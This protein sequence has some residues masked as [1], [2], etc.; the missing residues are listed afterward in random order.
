MEKDLSPLLDELPGL[1]W[2]ALPNGHLDFASLPWCEY[3]G[4]GLG[5]LYGEG[6]QRAIHPEDLPELLKRWRSILSAGEVNAMEARL[7]RFDGGYHWFTFRVRPLIDASGRIVKWLGLNVDI[8]DRGRSGRASEGLYRSITDTIPAMVFFMTPAGELES[9][10][11]HVLEYAGKTLEELKDW[12]SGNFVHADD[13]ASVIAAWDRSVTTGEPYDIE[14][15]MRR[16]DGI[17]RWFHVRGM[18]RRDVRGNI[19]RWYMIETDIDDRRRAETLL[20]GEKHLLEMTAAGSSMSDILAELCRFVEASTDGCYC[21]VVLLDA[22][23]ARLEQI[24]APSLPV[25][26]INSIIGGPVNIE[27]GPCAMA[28]YLNEQVIAPDLAL[29]TRWASHAWCPMAVAHG[30]RACWSTPILSTMGKVVGVF[31]IYYDT[32]QTPTP[33]QQQLVAQFSH[34]ASI[35]IER[36][37]S[38]AKLKQGEARKA[39]ILNAALDCIITIDHEG[40][41]IEFNPAAEQT[42]GYPRNMIVGRQLAD[43][44]IPPAMRRKHR[45][46]MARYIATGETRLIGRRVEMTALRADG[47]EFPVEL[48]ISRIPLEGAPSFTCYLRDIT[49]RKQSENELQRSGAFLTEAQRLSRTGSFSWCVPTGEIIWSEQVY[50][51][52]ELDQ[53]IPVTLDL[54][55]A[56]VHPEDIPLMRDMVARAEAEAEDFEYEHRLLLPDRSVK[57][58]HLVAHATRNRTGQIEYIGAVQDV[59]KRRLSEEALEEVRSELAHVVRIAS[60]G[61]LTAS[62]AHEVNQPLSGILTNASTC[63]RM[64]AADPPNIDG[65]RE[66]ARRT[67]RDGNRAADVIVRLRALFGKRKLTMDPVDLNE[68]T[69]EVIALLTNELR[70]DRVNVRTQLSDELPPVLGDRVQI[71]QVIL[72]LARNALDAMVDVDTRP[73]M[74]VVRTER[75]TDDGVRLTVQDAGVG[76]NSMDADRMFDAFFTTKENGMGIGLS[77]SR[78]I[79]ESHHGRIWAQPNDGYGASFSFSIPRRLENP[80]NHEHRI[81]SGPAVGGRT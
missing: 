42:F 10:N 21:S 71:Q 38:D 6:W 44:I 74:L 49:E 29:E 18:P 64:L 32:P 23:G 16:A 60:L 14:Q 59:T 11:Q 65:A 12:R 70:R 26:F 58:L 55:G 31:A 7:R 27:S 61:V 43:A 69:Q 45:Q 75:D 3:S 51:I 52:F 30:L 25:G 53:A 5:E 1:V 54:I 72:N 20:T 78:S 81:N 48:A 34:V 8:E 63:L 41:V 73:R 77:V 50:R 9:V 36:A 47:S 2:T 28:A 17:Y 57:Y 19:V 62:I 80:D 66:T 46:G 76:F 22:D 79:I 40:R 35:A 24:S 68:A 37:Q 56:R 13:L 67:I 15:R 33:E 39:A 4:L